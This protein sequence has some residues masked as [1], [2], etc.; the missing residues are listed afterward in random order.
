MD[1]TDRE[2]WPGLLDYASE[3]FGGHPEGLEGVLE[4]AAAAGLPAI[5]VGPETARLLQVLTRIT[6]GRLV[7]EVGTLAGYS[8][9]AIARAL[10]PE[11]KLITV[12]VSAVHAAVAAGEIARAG[13]TDRVTIRQGRGAEVL[14][15]LL[16]SLG[17]GCA[18]MVFL[19]ADRLG[20]AAL[21][22][23]VRALLRPGGVLA[24]DNALKARYCITD[25]PGENPDR[26]AMDA[27]NRTIADDEGFIATCAPIGNGVLLAVKR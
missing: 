27:F 6:G 19:D 22:P 26:D 12:E 11:G 14:P 23:T 8:A 16:A 10:A 21:L 24:A 3:V 17:P 20:Y 25:P 1:E 5:D 15:K 2:R 9:I 13:V 18:D 4:R 7:I